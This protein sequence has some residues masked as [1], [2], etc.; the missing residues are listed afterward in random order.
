MLWRYICTG[1]SPDD[2]LKSTSVFG[3]RCKQSKNLT[4]EIFNQVESKAILCFLFKNSDF[5]S[6]MLL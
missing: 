5:D 2:A 6:G 4:Q 3:R 1:V